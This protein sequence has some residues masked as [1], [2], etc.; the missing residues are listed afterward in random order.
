MMSLRIVL[1]RLKLRF[2]MWWADTLLKLEEDMFLTSH[3]RLTK[4]IISFVRILGTSNTIGTLECATGM[5][6]MVTLLQNM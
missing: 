6:L 3:L 5:E 2:L 1:P 4:I